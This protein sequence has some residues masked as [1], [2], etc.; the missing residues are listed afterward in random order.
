MTTRDEFAELMDAYRDAVRD[1]EQCEHW[2]WKALKRKERKA[3][4][5]LIDVYDQMSGHI[6]ELEA[7]CRKALPHLSGLLIDKWGS[8]DQW[9]ADAQGTHTVREMRALLK[10]AE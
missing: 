4:D 5:D 10:D 8:Q 7:A 6:A 1:T 2:E 9:P 3:D